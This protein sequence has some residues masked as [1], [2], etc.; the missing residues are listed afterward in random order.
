M[1]AKPTTQGKVRDIYD[2]GDRLLMVA[3]DR[4]SAY[5]VVLPVLI[6]D[7][8]RILTALSLFWFSRTQGL[9][10]NQLISH[11]LKDFPDVG[12]DPAYLQGRTLLVKKAEVIPIECVVRGYLAG[13]AWAEYQAKGTVC[14]RPLPEGMVESQQLP[15]AIFTP[16][17]KAKE[18]HDENITVPEMAGLV[19]EDV[20]RR[21]KQISLNLYCFAAKFALSR[22][23]IIA[24]TKFEF[25]FTEGQITLIDEVLTPDSSR[26][27]P[28]DG[29]EP[30]RSQPSFDKQYVRDWLDESGWDRRAPGPELPPPVIG[31]TGGKYIE[32]YERL[33][34]TKWLGAEAG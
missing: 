5:D 19:G 18:G 28:L 17:T 29:Y 30:G 33:T 11:R 23:I 14:G 4:I 13:S 1:S 10:P 26:L 15:E 34:G 27:W 20:T 25:G 16:S 8:G 24:D 21:L 2:L 6:P 3:T 32:A 7:K 9:V 12:L 31:R 22:G